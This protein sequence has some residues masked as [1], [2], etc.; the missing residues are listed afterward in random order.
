MHRRVQGWCKGRTARRTKQNHFIKTIQKVSAGAGA[1][2]TRA[3]GTGTGNILPSARRPSHCAISPI[4]HTFHS[5]ILCDS[6]KWAPPPPIP[7]LRGSGTRASPPP[8]IPYLRS[9]PRHLHSQHH[10]RTIHNT[11]EIHNEINCNEQNCWRRH[12]SS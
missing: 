3:P 8:P 1:G 7:Y 2:H 6:A 4:L 11:K 9:R 12:C 5:P 10:L